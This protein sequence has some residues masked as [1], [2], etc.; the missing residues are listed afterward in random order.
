MSIFCN[1]IMSFKSQT[2]REELLKRYFLG[3]SDVFAQW[4]QD[5][6]EWQC[7]RR[8]IP[9]Y[10]IKSHVEGKIALSTYPVSSLGNTPHLCFDLD[11]K[12]AEAYAILDWLQGWLNVRHMVFLI[13]DTGG[14]GLH[15][16]VLFL[17]YVPAVKAIALA[18]L[19]LNAYKSESGKLPCPAEIFPKQSKPRDVGNA[20]RLPWGKHQSGNWSHFI[21]SDNQH[22]DEGAIQ[23]ILNGK[24]T[25]EFDLDSLLPPLAKYPPEQPTGHAPQQVAEYCHVPRV[26]ACKWEQRFYVNIDKHGMQT[27]AVRS[28]TSQA[29]GCSHKFIDATRSLVGRVVCSRVCYFCSYACNPLKYTKSDMQTNVPQPVGVAGHE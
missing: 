24:K 15:G 3:R 10:L 23:A 27:L 9:Q 28:L 19:A 14:R 22:D 7:I 12:T 1:N 29:Q 18:D 20:I 13:E 11:N 16:W 17:G 21:G 26:T 5:I 25:T 6:C 8:Y 2:S 4:N